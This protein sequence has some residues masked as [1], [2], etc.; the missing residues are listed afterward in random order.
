MSNDSKNTAKKVRVRFAPSPTGYLHIG[1]AR[2]AL[3]NWLFARKYGGAFILRIEDT[4]IQRSQELFVEQI[5]TDLRWLKLEWDEGPDIGGE[6]GPYRQTDRIAVYQ[7]Y[8][9]KLLEESKAYYCYCQEEE[10]ERRRKEA[11]AKGETPKYDNRCRTLTKKEIAGYQNRGVRPAIRFKVEPQIIKVQDLIRGEVK[12]NA[13]LM[14]DFVIVKNDGIPAFNFAVTVD[15]CLM[16]ISHVIRGEDHLSNTPRHILLFRALGFDLPEFAHMSMVLGP[17]GTRLS[18][19]NLAAS[20]SEYRRLGYLPEAIINY[21]VLLGWSP[22]DDRE[23][24][25][26]EELVKRFEIKSLTKSSSIFDQE[27][28]NWLSGH[29]IRKAPLERITDLALTYLKEANLISG[30]LPQKKY[31]WLKMVV[32][33]SREHLS[34][35]SEITKYADIFLKNEIEIDD[36][37]AKG[38]LRNEQ[39]KQVLSA[40]SD[41]LKDM[42]R[43]EE[44]NF[45]DFI[46]QVQ[47]QSGTKGKNLYLP[48]RLALTGKFEG[49]ELLKIMPILGKKRCL[50]AF[51]SH[52]DPDSGSRAH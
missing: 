20:V 21:I 37:R 10:L 51:S 14:G 49:L 18:K 52:S 1:N 35:V 6:Y 34:S 31:N 41:I 4:D 38:V 19:R 32:E 13:G 30:R 29:Y 9:K 40:A 22:K 25:S 46:K 23:I 44:N 27:K 50:E 5:M 39:S 7:E 28:V 45:K 12:F 33:A 2:T 15:D 36:E 11:L 42:P 17:E 48:L 26:M 24:F 43:F 8:A 16:K 3:F 47:E